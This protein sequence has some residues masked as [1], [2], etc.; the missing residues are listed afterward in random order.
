MHRRSDMAV[1]PAVGRGGGDVR[2]MA[3]ARCRPC[4][5]STSNLNARSVS[6]EEKRRFE[7][8]CVHLLQTWLLVR[9][10]LEVVLPVGHG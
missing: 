8:V 1:S 4:D 2:D 5:A 3:G 10:L 6:L 9:G 7:R